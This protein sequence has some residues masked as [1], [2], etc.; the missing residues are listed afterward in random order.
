MGFFSRWRK[1][2]V[3]TE[4]GIGAEFPEAIGASKRGEIT[5]YSAERPI[6]GTAIAYSSSDFEATI[7]IRPLG[8][9]PNKSSAEFLTDSFAAIKELEAL[10]K[11][12]KVE[13]YLTATERERPGW[14]SG[15]FT[16]RS[17]EAFIISF[18]YCK[19]VAG[20]LVKVRITTPN[21]KNDALQ[22]FIAELQEIVERA[23]RK[24]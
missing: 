16:A 7:Y 6:E 3:Y 24:I 5:P 4:P 19:I 10:G 21:P 1:S 9:E 17:G 23:A 2:N 14:K 22:S 8:N 11:Y 13:I 12:A 18:I 15:A 20:H